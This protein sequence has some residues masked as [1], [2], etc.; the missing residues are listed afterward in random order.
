MNILQGLFFAINLLLALTM[1]AM[2]TVLPLITRKSLLF[3]VRI[4]ESALDHPRVRQLKTRYLAVLLALSVL[5]LAAALV[6]HLTRPAYN[7]IASLYLPLPLLIGQFL[8]TVA[9]W[10][11]AR[12]LKAQENWQVAHLGTAETR[13]SRARTAFGGLPWAWYLGSL[14]LLVLAVLVSLAVYPSMPQTI[15]THWNAAMEPDAWAEKSLIHV[16]IMPIIALVMI[17]IMLL[18]NLAIYRTKLQVSLENPALSYAQ[19]RVYRLW[20]SHMLGFITAI[21]TIMFLAF[22]PMV[23]N[24]WVPSSGVMILI[25]LVTSTLMIVPA[26]V[27]SVK[28]GQGGTRLKPAI[29]QAD[30]AAAGFADSSRPAMRSGRGDDRF[31][32]LGMFYVNPEDPALFVEDRLGNNG[33]LNYAR[34]LAWVMVVVL[35]GLIIATYALSTALLLELV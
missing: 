17:V 32:K 31:W 33:G 21:M 1:G 27:V 30:V 7:L 13:S 3:G 23:L 25:I 16:L 22:Q 34:P 26:I 4:P 5:T 15:V 6:V 35:L 24:L 18:S 9:L 14:A 19:H 10:R 20:M 11:Q 2:L 8:T 28:A 12:R 29:T